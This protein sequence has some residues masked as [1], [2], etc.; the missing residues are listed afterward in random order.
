MGWVQIK[1]FDG[2]RTCYEDDDVNGIQ[3]VTSA[4]MIF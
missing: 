4:N 2:I 3:A 1:T